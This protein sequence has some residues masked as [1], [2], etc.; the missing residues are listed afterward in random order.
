MYGQQQ[1]STNSSANK[2]YSHPMYA[3]GISAANSRSNAVN[4][5]KTHQVGENPGY[6]SSKP[7]KTNKHTRTS[8]SMVTEDLEPKHQQRNKQYPQYNTV[9]NSQD[10]SKKPNLPQPSRASRDAQQ[11]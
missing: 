2:E 7:S 11:Q 6:F 8:S 10:L 4:V 5:N 1:K 9:G 3:I